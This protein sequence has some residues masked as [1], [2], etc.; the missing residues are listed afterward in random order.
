MRSKRLPISALVLFACVFAP[1]APG[2]EAPE[3]PPLVNIRAFMIGGRD[4]RQVHLIGEKG[5]VSLRASGVQPSR[6]SKV[7][8]YNPLPVFEDL[9]EAWDPES[10][11]VPAARVSLPPDTGH[12][13]L[14]VL[15]DGDRVRYEAVPD[16]LFKATSRDW[17]FLNTTDKP[18][19]FRLGEDA[20]PFIINPRS[21]KSHR[22]TTSEKK[23]AAV[24]AAARIQGEPTTFYST[25]WPLHPDRRGMVLFVQKENGG[26]R[27]RLILDALPSE[28]PQNAE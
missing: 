13:L 21:Q 9:P 19:V 16:D 1:R 17:R 11:P 4:A 7:R 28:E 24:T 8:G 27:I 12:L 23:G 10:P 20:K 15:P 5:F 26:I 3:P 22:L 18:I 2:Q 14:L 6:T 25:Y